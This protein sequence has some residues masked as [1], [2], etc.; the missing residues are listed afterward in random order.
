[1]N[2]IQKET[3]KIRVIDIKIVDQLLGQDPDFLKV[4]EINQTQNNN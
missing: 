4:L 3:F 1:M 2:Q